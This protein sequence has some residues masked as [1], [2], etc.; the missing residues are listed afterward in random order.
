MTL[1][2]EMGHGQAEICRSDALLLVDTEASRKGGINQGWA[3]SLAHLGSQIGSHFALGFGLLGNVV[4]AV[5]IL[6]KHFP[7]A[8]LKNENQI[9]VWLKLF[10]YLILE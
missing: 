8:L 7:P 4:V 5:A 6:R 3:T 1:S 9:G 10:K 2:S